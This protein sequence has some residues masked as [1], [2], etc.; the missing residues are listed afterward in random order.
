MLVMYFGS[1]IYVFYNKEEFNKFKK[2]YE[3][4][5]KKRFK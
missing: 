3:R 2:A 5:I 4:S 1:K